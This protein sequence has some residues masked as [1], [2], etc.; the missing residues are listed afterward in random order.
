MKTKISI[1]LFALCIFTAQAQI[2][3]VL[4][5]TG[6]A[7]G[8]NPI[9][10]LL[11]D[12]T[13][14]YGVTTSGGADSAGIIYKVKPD[15]TGYQKLHDFESGL[16]PVGSLVSDGVYLYGTSATGGGIGNTGAVYKIK[17]DGTGYFQFWHF[18]ISPAAGH[19][20][21]GSLIYDSPWLY[22]MTKVGGGYGPGIVY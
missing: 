20:P 5:F 8:N 15:G 12:G 7:N 2:T 10:G 3:K 22:G 1:A 14:F 19:F 21:V 17:P 18:G 13:Y 11:F 4:E 9:G 16:S 6:G